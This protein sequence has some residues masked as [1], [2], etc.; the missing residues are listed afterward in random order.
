MRKACSGALSSIL[1]LKSVDIKVLLWSFFWVGT[2]FNH[3]QTFSVIAHHNPS[4]LRALLDCLRDYSVILHLNRNS[5]RD[6]FEFVEQYENVYLIPKENSVRV[7]WGTNQGYSK[8]IK[9]IWE[10]R[11]EMTAQSPLRLDLPITLLE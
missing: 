2:I 3:V 8:T 9:P 1:L 11:A 4:A 7:N 6:Q 5:P 10:V